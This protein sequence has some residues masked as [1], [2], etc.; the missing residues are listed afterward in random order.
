[1]TLGTR[2]T[3]TPPPKADSQNLATL[4]TLQIN[5][6]PIVVKSDDWQTFIAINKNLDITK[7]PTNDT[8]VGIDFR[9]VNNVRCAW[10][11]LKQSK[12]GVNEIHIQKQKSNFTKF[13]VDCNP[14]AN[15]S[16]NEMLPA[17]W[18]KASSSQIRTVIDVGYD[19]NTGGFYRVWNDGWKEQGGRVNI[20]VDSAATVTFLKPFSNANYYANWISCN[21]AVISGQGTRSADTLTTTTMRLFNGQDTVMT[22]NWYACGF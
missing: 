5:T 3:I 11:G 1:M 18:F 7:T 10:F 17:K 9:D 6:Q 13:L 20:P 2:F 16:G 12:N 21:G 15:S 8:Y 22:A 19:A 14:P 4:D